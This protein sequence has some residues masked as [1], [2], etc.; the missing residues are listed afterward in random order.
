MYFSRLPGI[1]FGRP[2][3]VRATRSLAA[4]RRVVGRVSG[5]LNSGRAV[6]SLRS[7]TNFLA[8]D[9]DLT[10]SSR[11]SRG[12]DAVFSGYGLEATFNAPVKQ[13]PFFNG[14]KD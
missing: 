4:S 5:F 8:R 1:K 13:A 10:I 3:S 6:R 9:S 14:F 2:S 7:E 12:F 11:T